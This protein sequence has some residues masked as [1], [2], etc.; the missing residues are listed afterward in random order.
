MSEITGR[1]VIVTGGAGGIGAAV[2]RGYCAAGARVVSMDLQDEYGQQVAAEASD[3]GP[4]GVTYLRTDVSDPSSV[5]R[6]FAAAVA[7]LGGLDVLAHT[8][9]VHRAAPA[10][11]IEDDDWTRILAV[12]AGGTMLTNRAAFEPMR[13]AG[14][15]SIINFGSNAGLAGVAGAAAYSA[16]KG[17]VHSWTR[18]VARE[19]GRHTTSVSTR[20]RR[21]S[22]RRCS[23]NVWLD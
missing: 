21:P 8:A 7:I 23:G 2:V 4:G 13:A 3:G 19:W 15:G 10:E 17:A 16:S 9:G 5:D 11:E 14:G 22:T 1:R 6:Q 12:N 20:S 18:T